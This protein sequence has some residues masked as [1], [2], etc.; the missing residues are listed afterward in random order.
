MTP[1]SICP[2][3]GVQI[4]VPEIDRQQREAFARL[5]PDYRP[6]RLE[7]LRLELIEALEKM[8]EGL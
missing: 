7:K 1:G 4:G 3:T 6:E 5:N 2:R 8:G